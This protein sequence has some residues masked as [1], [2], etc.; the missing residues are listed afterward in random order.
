MEFDSAPLP[1]WVIS[2]LSGTQRMIQEIS[3]ESI[4][5]YDHPETM[6]DAHYA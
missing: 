4:I 5:F 3:E 1:N 2:H 6:Q